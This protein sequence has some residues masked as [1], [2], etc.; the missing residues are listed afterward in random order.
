MEG[1]GMISAISSGK[2][3]LALCLAALAAGVPPLRTIVLDWIVASDLVP[4][5][6]AA[7]GIEDAGQ[8]IAAPN[9]AADA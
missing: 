9:V 3:A 4:G 2:I 1:Y 7:D 5:L 6:I 8:A